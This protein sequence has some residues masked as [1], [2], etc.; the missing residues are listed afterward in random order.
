MKI[1][2]IVKR[3]HLNSS[4][5]TTISNT[6]SLRVTVTFISGKGFCPNQEEGY[7]LCSTWL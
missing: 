7:E 6:S 5:K 1:F 3:T 4:K 2:P